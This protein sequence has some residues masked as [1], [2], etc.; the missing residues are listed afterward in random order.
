MLLLLYIVN[1]KWRQ[2]NSILERAPG[3]LDFT[4]LDISFLHRA[5]A[6]ALQ[7]RSNCTFLP[8]L[9][10]GKSNESIKHMQCTPVILRRKV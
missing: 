10:I 2:K 6:A 4:S 9:F 8:G 7:R 5:A 1:E 3:R